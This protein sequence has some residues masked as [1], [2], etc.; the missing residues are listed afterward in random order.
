[1]V[2]RRKPENPARTGPS[3]QRGQLPYRHSLTPDLCPLTMR[4]AVG[5]DHRGVE[6]RAKLIEFLRQLGQ[7]VDDLGTYDC[8]EVD[9]PDIAAAV[10]RKGRRWRGR[11]QDSRLR[12]RCR[13]VYRGQ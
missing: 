4:I 13:H 9:Y 8:Q 11:S 7:E 6:L 12:D 2:R 1:M 10:A 5:S 3:W